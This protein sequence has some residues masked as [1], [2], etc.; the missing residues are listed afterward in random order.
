M[1]IY[2]ITLGSGLA[3]TNDYYIVTQDYDDCSEALEVL[4][5]LMSCQH[6]H[7]YHNYNFIGFKDYDYTNNDMAI[8][9]EGEIIYEDEYISV[10]NG[11]IYHGGQADMQLIG[12]IEDIDLP[13]TWYD[14]DNQCYVVNDLIQRCGHND[15]CSCYGKLHEGQIADIR[16]YLSYAINEC[17]EGA[18]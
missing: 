16:S 13:S 1:K 11:I 2:K 9:H 15:Q 5:D 10:G 12:Y 3:W 14:Y 8:I 4:G 17:K 6:E 18:Y 7:G